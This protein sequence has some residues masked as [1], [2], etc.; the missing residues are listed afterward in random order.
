MLGK[1]AKPPLRPNA[2]IKSNYIPLEE[3]TLMLESIVSP[4]NFAAS[5]RRNI[6]SK[7]DTSKL[8]NIESFE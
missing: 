6:K 4:L 5:T 3:L 1:S 8:I 2:L 7:N